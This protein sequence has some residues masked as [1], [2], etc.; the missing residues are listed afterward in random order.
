MRVPGK[1]AMNRAVIG[2]FDVSTIVKHTRQKPLAC[3]K[4]AC[5]FFSGQSYKAKTGRSACAILLSQK[6]ALLHFLCHLSH[7]KSIFASIVLIS[8]L[9]HSGMKMRYIFFSSKFYNDM[10]KAGRPHVCIIDCLTVKPT[11]QKLSERLGSRAGPNFQWCCAQWGKGRPEGYCSM[12][13]RSFIF[14]RTLMLWRIQNL[15]VAGA[16][17]ARENLPSETRFC[18]NTSCLMIYCHIYQIL[19]DEDCDFQQLGDSIDKQTA[20]FHYFSWNSAV[21][22]CFSMKASKCQKTQFAMA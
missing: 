12:R 20:M 15:F 19:T 22:I 11:M 13:A 10:K 18:W 3:T 16:V 2:R 17:V 5:S 7:L 1:K 14:G 6:P 4:Q 9:F 21:C 8:S